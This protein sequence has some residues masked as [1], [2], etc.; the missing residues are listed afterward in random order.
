MKQKATDSDLLE[1]ELEIRRLRKEIRKKNDRIKKL[2]SGEEINYLYDRLKK[3]GETRYNLILRVDS[4][5][6][7]ILLGEEKYKRLEAVHKKLQ[8]KF[9]VNFGFHEYI[10]DALDQTANLMEKYNAVRKQ[11][12]AVQ[13]RVQAASRKRRTREPHGASAGAAVVR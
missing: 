12:K 6:K 4:L 13:K 3:D 1:L 8:E 7:E 10:R 9:E 5:K 11:G 2:K